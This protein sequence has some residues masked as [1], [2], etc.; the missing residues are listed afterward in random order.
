[1]LVG[2]V[3]KNYA[4]I[5]ELEIHPSPHLNVVTGETG[6]GKSIML[7]AIG[8]LL[9]NRADGKALWDENEKCIVEGIFDISSYKLQSAFESANLDYEQQAVIRREISPGGKSRAFINDTPVTLEIMRSIGGRLMDVHS[10]HETL[11]LGSRVFQLDFID[12]YASNLSLKDKYKEAW[13]SF[14]V[15]KTNFESLQKEAALLKQESDFVKFQL[16][17]LTKAELQSD[18]QEKLESELKV[19]EHAEEI[20]I[21]LNTIVAHLGQSEF[22]VSP[23]LSVVRNMLHSISAYSPDYQKLYDRLESVRLELDDILNEVERE[24]ERVE[25]DPKRIAK[26]KDRLS[27]IYQLMQK[28]RMKDVNELLALQ[29]SL[30]LKF[31]KTSNLDETLLSAKKILESSGNELKRTAQDLTKSREKVF[32]PLCKQVTQSLL[33]LGIPNAVLKIEHQV[34]EPTATGQDY[35]ELLFSANKGIAPKPLAQ[36]ASGG[37]FSRLMFSIK[38]V[39]AAKTA[40]PTLVLDEIDNGISGEIAIQL[41]KMMKEMATRHQLITITHLPQIAAKG[42]AHYF[43][44]KDNKASKTISLVKQLLP[45]ERIDEIAKM[46]AGANP[47]RLALENARELMSE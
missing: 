22:A 24:E 38:Y 23:V 25:F 4:L 43:V 39:M 32:S 44:Y 3:I 5:R 20:K 37:E 45:D 34:V 12:S 46:I 7:G 35:V 17:E 21:Q 18:E 6:A 11:E 47:S 36:V 26:T 19:M 27:L 2:L 31:D 9:G 13:K 40:L 33:D 1:M 10:Q 29:E 42:D 15:A 30:Q 28:H 8:L 14:V 16:E 41:G